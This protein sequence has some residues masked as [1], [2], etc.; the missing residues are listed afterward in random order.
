MNGQI[1]K[2]EKADIP[3][4][5]KVLDSSA[6]FPSY[7]LD[8]MISDYLSNE[9]STDIWFT[10]IDQGKPISIGY[11]APERLTEGTYNL[12]AIAVNKNQQGKGI[13]KKMMEYIEN[14]LR[15]NGNRILIVETSGKPEFE[16]TREFYIKCN[17]KKQAVIPE[18]YEKGD[19][20][21]VFWKKLTE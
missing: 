8:D 20:K 7:L 3:E 13:G 14:E 15:K 5:K 11:C 21:I 2:V 1:R 12:Y 16:L 6:L 4:L 17:Y 19:D 18:F 9:K 10:T